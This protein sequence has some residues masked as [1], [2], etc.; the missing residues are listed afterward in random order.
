M[1]DAADAF[2][3][4]R[5]FAQSLE[6][7]RDR[8]RSAVPWDLSASEKRLLQFRCALDGDHAHFL[9]EWILQAGIMR[10][11]RGGL[12]CWRFS[13]GPSDFLLLASDVCSISRRDFNHL[14]GE[15]WL[16]TYKNARRVFAR[17]LRIL[18]VLG[19][20]VRFNGGSR[21]GFAE[22]KVTWDNPTHREGGS[23]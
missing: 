22:Y 11:I 8:K 9:A 18:K 21:D 7:P 2:E 20:T 12:H 17:M 23:R 6:I 10:E 13:T 4:T 19:Y 14:L 16:M 5:H 3:L 15:D 1:I